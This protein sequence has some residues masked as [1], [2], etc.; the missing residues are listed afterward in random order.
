M[1]F[2]FPSFSKSLHKFCNSSDVKFKINLFKLISFGK[3]FID[4]FFIKFG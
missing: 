2:S 4:L 1:N 3:N